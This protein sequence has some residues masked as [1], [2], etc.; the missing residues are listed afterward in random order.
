MKDGDVKCR[1]VYATSRCPQSQNICRVCS[2]GFAHSCRNVWWAWWKAT[3][4]Q[5]P[6]IY[7]IFGTC[8]SYCWHRPQGPI[9]QQLFRDPNQHLRDKNCPRHTSVQDLYAVRVLTHSKRISGKGMVLLP[10]DLRGGI[11]HSHPQ[12]VQKMENTNCSHTKE[13][14]CICQDRE[15]SSFSMT[16]GRVITPKCVPKS[17]QQGVYATSHIKW[18]TLLYEFLLSSQTRHFFLI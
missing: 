8:R 5:E 15:E 16:T 18:T 11:G 7:V 4:P 3:L 17:S 12:T 9:V 10:S 13:K 1:K 2:V 14:W 6:Q